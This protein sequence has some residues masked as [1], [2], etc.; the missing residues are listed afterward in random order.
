MSEVSIEDELRIR[1][2]YN[3]CYWALN[4]GDQQGVIDCFAPDG[5]IAVS[6]ASTVGATRAK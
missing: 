4:S 1:R 2:L 6:M 5:F 3:R